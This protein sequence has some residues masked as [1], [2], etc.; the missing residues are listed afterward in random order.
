MGKAY[1]YISSSIPSLSPLI[2][3]Q[4]TLPNTQ[5]NAKLT[6]V[7]IPAAQAAG[8]KALRRDQKFIVKIMTTSGTTS[9]YGTF[10][11]RFDEDE[12]YQPEQP[13]NLYSSPT[14]SKELSKSSDMSTGVYVYWDAQKGNTPSFQTTLGEIK[15]GD[16]YEFTLMYNEGDSFDGSDSNTAHQL[17]E[18]SGRGT[19]DYSS[20]KCTCLAGYTGEACQRTACPNQCSGHGSCQTE[21]RFASDGLS[22]NSI[23]YTAY[24]GDQQYG[25]KCDKGYRG[26]DC[27]LGECTHRSLLPRRSGVAAQ[28]IM[29]VDQHAHPSSSELFPY[30]SFVFSTCS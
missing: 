15:E 25:C 2:F 6:A 22:A 28:S 21:L 8:F 9:P 20:G 16:S 17:T 24:D 29:C 7:F 19:C 30:F 23:G 27:S 18:C 4:S 10:A 3:K 14:K 11:W 13:I 12:Y 26:P 1:D 5:S